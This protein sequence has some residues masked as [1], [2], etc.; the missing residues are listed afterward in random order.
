MNAHDGGGGGGGGKG[1]KSCGL[2]AA[3][4]GSLRAKNRSLTQA[5]RA[6]RIKKA[7]NSSKLD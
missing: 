7:K 2:P 3:K 1:G 6:M 5:R 4:C